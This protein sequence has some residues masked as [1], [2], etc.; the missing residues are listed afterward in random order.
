MKYV[1]DNLEINELTEIFEQNYIF[2]DDLFLLNKEDF[3]EMKIPIGPRNRLINF[4]D[5]FKSTTKTYNFEELSSFMDKYKQILINSNDIPNNE[6][7]NVTPSTESK[8]KSPISSENNKNRGSFDSHGSELPGKGLNMSNFNLEENETISPRKEEAFI[9]KYINSKPKNRYRNIDDMNKIINNT[10]KN[11]Y[12]NNMKDIKLKN[13]IEDNKNNNNKNS[14]NIIN[15]KKSYTSRLKNKYDQ[16][17]N[18]KNNNYYNFNN[19]NENNNGNIFSNSLYN[20]FNTNIKNINKIVDMNNNN[21]TNNYNNNAPDSI[22]KDKKNARIFQVNQ[23][24]NKSNE[25]L[26]NII[27]INSPNK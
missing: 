6:N 2:F 24:Q 27:S 4:I 7:I 13:D 11:N 21:G 15:N 22:K 12:E 10:N 26:N 20:E 9:N 19:N 14:S 23:N 18:L 8:Y 5:K 3:V 16:F 1:L 25:N 17:M